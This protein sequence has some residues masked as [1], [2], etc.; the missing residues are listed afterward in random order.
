[1]QRDE[2][3]G[4]TFTG[5][6]LQGKELFL[7]KKLKKCFHFFESYPFLLDLVH[8]NVNDVAL[9]HRLFSRLLM[10]SNIFGKSGCFLTQRLVLQR[11]DWHWILMKRCRRRIDFSPLT[12]LKT[13]MPLFWS[14]WTP[15]AESVPDSELPTLES[16]RSFPRRPQPPPPCPDCTE[17]QAIN[18][19]MSFVNFHVPLSI[20]CSPS[21]FESF[22]AF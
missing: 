13:W 19:R 16:A 9:L 21:V 1:M 11:V 5:V 18:Q 10:N 14:R 17:F 15:W 6:T 22:F 3:N 12:A 20:F 4:W 2:K 8:T 7:Y